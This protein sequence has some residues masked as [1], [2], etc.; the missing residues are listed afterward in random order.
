V[1]AAQ[2]HWFG[3]VNSVLVVVVMSG[4]V[5]MI[6]ART[7]HRDLVK[8]EQLVMEG[9]SLDMKDEAGWKLV[10]GDVFRT[11]QASRRLAVQVRKRPSW[12][13][14]CTIFN[15]STQGRILDPSN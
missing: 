14:V 10:A 9:S 8:Y 7:V 12:D 2:V 15:Y 6:L 5:A 3:I 1:H 13:S 4:I 11:P